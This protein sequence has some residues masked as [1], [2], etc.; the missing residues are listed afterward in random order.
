[1]SKISELP[2]EH[3]LGVF[4]DLLT[5]DLL[6]AVREYPGAQFGQKNFFS[7]GQRSKVKG[8]R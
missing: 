4:A 8:Q 5:F 3:P 7:K 2:N 6:H 1:M